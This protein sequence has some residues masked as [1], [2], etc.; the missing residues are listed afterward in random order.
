MSGPKRD[1]LVYSSA[2]GRRCAR[3]EQP[4][5]GCRCRES[6]RAA[7]GDGVVRI[8]REI[9]GRRGKTVTAI[10]GIALPDGELRALAGE[11]KRSCGTGGSAKDGVIEIQGDHRDALAALLRAK[12][13]VVKLA[14]G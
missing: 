11:L 13:Y 12:G 5:A 3:C 14:G 4:I 7:R 8:R 1:P 9:G 6:A 2:G 10:S